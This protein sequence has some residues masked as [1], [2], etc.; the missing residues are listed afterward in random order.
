VPSMPRALFALVAVLLA[1]SSPLVSGA[2]VRPSSKA[3]VTTAAVATISLRGRTGI[4]GAWRSSLR[5]RLRRTAI[6]TSFSLCAVW[7][8]PP[9]LTPECD[10]PSGE[11]LPEGSTMR[12]EQSRKLVNAAWKRVGFS[13]GPALSA[14]LSNSVSGNRLGTVFYRVTL[15]QS[16]GTVLRTSNTFRVVW[17]K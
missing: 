7:G 2:S 12:L 10:A 8:D 3:G 17:H 14:V 9:S 16:T 6:P 11:R 4:E 13:A 5:L 15:R 1:L